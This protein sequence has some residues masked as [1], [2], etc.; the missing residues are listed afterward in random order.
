MAILT[1]TSILVRLARF[2]WSVVVET[3][4][5]SQQQAIERRD[6]AVQVLVVRRDNEAIGFQWIAMQV[7]N[8]GV[9][10]LA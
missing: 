3:Q 9:V 10:D 7:I 5:S 4:K 6:V 1:D 8:P 2:E